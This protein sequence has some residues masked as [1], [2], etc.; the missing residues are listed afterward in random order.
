VNPHQPIRPEEREACLALFSKIS[1]ATLR[2]IALNHLPLWEATGLAVRASLEDGDY[3][4][5]VPEVRKSLRDMLT[6]PTA[7]DHGG[8]EALRRQRIIQRRQNPTLDEVTVETYAQAAIGAVLIPADQYDAL[9]TE[10]GIAP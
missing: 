8:D 6:T 10:Y 4:A 7:H 9:L 5:T 1:A 2:L 3:L